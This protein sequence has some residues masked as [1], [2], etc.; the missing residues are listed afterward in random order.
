[1]TTLARTPVEL[2][3]TTSSFDAVAHYLW[4]A[5]EQAERGRSLYGFP[6]PIN[7]A[8]VPLQLV[9]DVLGSVLDLIESGTLVLW[10]IDDDNGGTSFELGVVG[11]N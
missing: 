11:L 6:L 8:P 4:H 10:S 9:R 3:V 5:I 1:M 7:V 2:A